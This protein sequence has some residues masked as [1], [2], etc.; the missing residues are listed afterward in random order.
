MKDEL[1]FYAKAGLLILLGALFIWI[2]Y[3][4]RGVLWPFV[5]AF[6]LSY[7]LT[8]VVEY[9]CNKKLPRL[10]A[11][12]LTYTILV[13][14]LVLIMLV[15]IPGLINTLR[16]ISGELPRY[17]DAVKKYMGFLQ[18]R[19]EQLGLPW[20]WEELT[21]QILRGINTLL[22]KAM[23]NITGIFSG[24]FLF[25]L[26][27]IVSFYLL[28][29]ARKIRGALINYTPKNFQKEVS[30][31]LTEVDKVLGGYVRGQ[32]VIATI[33][34]VSIG[35]GLFLLNIKY[36]F[37]LGIIA[38]AFNIVPYLGPVIAII[39]ALLLAL[40]KDPTSAWIFV[41]IV[42]LFTGVNQVE[43]LFLSPHILGREVRLHPVA[44]IFAIIVGG[45]ALGM[46]GV[47]LA[48]P[49]LALLKALFIRLTQKKE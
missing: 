32:L 33:V 10:L 8:P 29:D 28:K 23:A 11:V 22:G 37:L 9:L 19:Y 7:I 24:I 47:L 16:E 49:A 4:A 39:P 38:G 46:M 34:G 31:F 35:I 3:M 42:L 5:L 21:G 25:I 1:K 20:E 43:A 17:V 6:L 18:K 14:I 27:L 15:I 45:A 40:T 36:A 12:F 26:S 2:L 44:V 13:A 48:I 30:E 41:W